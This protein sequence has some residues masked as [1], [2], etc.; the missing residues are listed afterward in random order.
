ML[1][2]GP[3]DPLA[4]PVLLDN[5]DRMAPPESPASQPNPQRLSL[6][7]PVLLERSEN[8]VPMVH[9]AK[10]VRMESPVLRVPKVPTVN[11]VKMVVTD[12]QDNRDLLAPT[13]K[14]V[15]PEFARNIAPSTVESSSKMAH[16]DNPAPPRSSH[17]SIAHPT[18]VQYVEPRV[19]SYVD[20]FD[21]LC[22]CLLLLFVCSS[23]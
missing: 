3:E 9:P 21:G 1:P 11:P 13:V 10:P 20:N 6:E 16:D 18:S 2:L 14:L 7:R 17:P 19:P 8:K 4:L 22:Y 15:S 5:Q 23:K 12:N